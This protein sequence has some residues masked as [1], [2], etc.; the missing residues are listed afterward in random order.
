MTKFLK[1][2]VL[3]KRCGKCDGSGQVNGGNHS[4]PF[5][6]ACIHCDGRGLI[7]A[8]QESELLK[9]AKQYEELVYIM[10]THDKQFALS[11]DK[12]IDD[13]PLSE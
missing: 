12:I 3:Y 7:E 11:A 5:M 2:D 4:Q 9:K 8:K 13:Q 10:R 1:P 6:I